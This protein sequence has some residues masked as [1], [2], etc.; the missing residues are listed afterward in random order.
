MNESIFFFVVVVE[1][2][3]I[4]NVCTL[5]VHLYK[6]SIK[7]DNFRLNLVII[8]LEVQFMFLVEH[9]TDIIKLKVLDSLG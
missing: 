2:F 3:E 8:S 7:L 1:V 4:F 5:L 6:S 9:I